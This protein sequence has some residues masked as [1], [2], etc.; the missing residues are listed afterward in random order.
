MKKI[1]L[2][3]SWKMNL[4]VTESLEYANKLNDLINEIIPANSL[5]EVYIFPD[6]LSLY[7]ISLV[8]SKSRI[9]LGAQDC[10]WEDKGPYTGEISPWS[11][12]AMGC[13]YVMAGHPERVNYFKEDATVINKKVKAIL[14]NNMTPALFVVEKEK[15]PEIK[16]TCNILK[17]QLFPLLEGIEKKDLGKIV[18]FYEPVPSGR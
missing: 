15:K 3:T 14:R 8:L 18:I 7:P 10:F 17:D 9:K 2:C 13:D 6:F 12:K 5:I 16:D 4:S 1:Y 11:L